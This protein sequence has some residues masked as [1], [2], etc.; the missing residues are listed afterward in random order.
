M[1]VHQFLDHHGISDNPFA[2]EDAQTDS[3]FT[4][5]CIKGTH[6][7]AWD[8][9]FGKPNEPATSVVFGEKG[10]GKTALRLQMVNG[11]HDWNRGNPENRTWLVQ[12][13]DF[14][15]FLDAFREKLAGYR[16]K[17]DRALKSWQLIDHIDAIL[18]LGVTR[19]I[20]IILEKQQHYD[21]SDTISKDQLSRL[22]RTDTRDLLLLAALY[23]RS[24]EMTREQRWDTVRGKLGYTAWTRMWPLGVGILFTIVAPILFFQFGD[25]SQGKTWMWLA[26]VLLVG[27]GPYL[28]KQLMLWWK[29]FRIDRNIRILDHNSGMLR[30]VLGKFYQ[31]ELASQ[32]MPTNSRSDTRYEL[33]NKFQ[34]IIR[35]LGFTQ[36]M[37]FVDRVDE[38]HLIEGVPERMKDLLWPM[39]DNKFLKHPG[40][41]FKMLLPAEV[42]PLL[43]RQEKQFYER[44][45]LDKQNLISSLNWTG[46]GLYD[47]TN[48]R[49][50]VCSRN[51]EKA[52][53]VMDLFEP[54]MT[55]AEL[56][57]M[58]AHLRVPRHLFKFL[59]RLLVA[60]CSKYTDEQPNY[61]ISRGTFQTT[62][63]VFE[64]EL[65]EF[66]RGTGMI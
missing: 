38:P 13:E 40:I 52:E 61:K 60:H 3:I 35:K 48:D 41:G 39:F 30:R 55:K 42:Y 59:Y 49:I 28:Y 11:I 50:R 25:L 9:I 14:N 8:K 15:P 58:F 45:R 43:Q 19:L 65:A 44:S 31:P 20:N 5:H 32:P 27:W 62:L 47:V 6:H 23:D 34:S 29:A 24:L 18:S 2:Q 64:K 66:D 63:A 17:P 33:L 12:Y 53:S 46:E 4:K 7:P 57:G 26:I 22:E 36:M 16:R 56:I 51:P 10:A 21:S 1:K 54:E 37:I